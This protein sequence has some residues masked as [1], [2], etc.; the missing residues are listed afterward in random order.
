MENENRR[1]HRCSEESLRKELGLNCVGTEYNKKLISEMLSVLSNTRILN[2]GLN[3]AL[4]MVA[5]QYGFEA[6]LISEFIGNGLTKVTNCWSADNISSSVENDI[7]NIENWD[8]FLTG[9]DEQ[10]YFAVKD[11]EQ[12][13]LSEYDRAFLLQKSVHAFVSVLIFGNEKPIAYLALERRCVIKKE[14]KVGR[15]TLLQAAKIFSAF[16]ESRIQRRKDM[17]KITELS[18]D[19]LTGLLNFPAFQRNARKHLAN[20]EEGKVYAIVASDISNFSSL[21]KNYGYQE[22]DRILK[23]FGRLLKQTS[24]S[25]DLVCRGGADRFYALILS[26]DHNRIESEIRKVNHEFTTYLTQKYP[27]RGLC[28]ATGIRY[29]TG[30][31]ENIRIMTDEANYARKNAK[32]IHGDNIGIFSEELQ[33]KRENAIQIVESIEGAIR[34]GSVEL[35]L[36]PKFSI[37]KRTTIGAEALVRWR[38]PDGTYK[39]PDQF[40]PI[41]EETGLI[42]ELDL[43]IYQ[44]VLQTL[45]RWRAE[46]RKLIPISVNTSRVDFE[47][48]NFAT[49]L[50]D[51]ATLFDIPPCYIEF[52]VTE[53]AMIYHTDRLYRQLNLLRDAGFRID[54]DDFG[55]GQS[56]LNMLI[57]APVDIIK[58][59]KSFL[60]HFKTK[61]EKDYIRKICELIHVARKEGIFE[62][63]ETEEQMELL[64]NCGCDNAQGYFYS[65]PIP[66][67][68]FEQGFLPEKTAAGA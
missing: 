7:I 52:E 31:E 4:Q 66:V 41:L 40:I 67:E 21:N 16:L 62:G 45:D 15:Q 5:E 14:T 29:V 6:A 68:S 59:D 60:F 63:V 17:H 10:G 20:M 53:G 46:H 39:F 54:M 32:S 43:S 55:T 9:Y 56:S 30:S 50:I 47:D 19:E 26:T 3:A 35:F 44:Q 24:L 25:G 64:Q 36:Q 57:D 8:S 42:T 18:V 34:D 12:S 61:Q 13:S 51:M 58:V 33:K 48:E 23:E 1:N 2:Q 49:R 22:G 38:N 11:V 37:S 27:L 65:K 28:I